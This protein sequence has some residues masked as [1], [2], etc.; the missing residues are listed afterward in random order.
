M[1]K[2]YTYSRGKTVGLWKAG[3]HEHLHG[4]EEE[5]EEEEEEE[6]AACL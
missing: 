5:E 6:L 3:S 4:R 1:R 2:T